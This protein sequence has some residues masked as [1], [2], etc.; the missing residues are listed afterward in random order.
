MTVFWI[1]AALML[2]AALGF[3]LLPLARV[4]K[5]PDNDSRDVNVAVYRGQLQELRTD[6][7]TGAI[8]DDQY[9]EA[10][11]DLER[12]LVQDTALPA[13]TPPAPKRN[14]A[15]TTSLAAGVAAFAIALYFVVGN[16]RALSPASFT[17]QD[18][19]A[20]IEQLAQHLEQDP[21]NAEGW[22]LL[23]RSYHGL[24]QYKE[25]A[26][27]FEKASLLTPDDAQ[28]LADYA[29]A[30]ARA[31]EG[32][33]EGKPMLLLA[34][35]LQADPENVKALA[36]SGAGAY[37][38][39]DYKLAA[40]H[41]QRLLARIPAE[42]EEAKLVQERIAEARTLAAAGSPGTVNIRGT[43]K[44]S[45]RLQSRVGGEDTL[46]VYAQ[47]DNSRMPLAIVRA[48][49]KELPYSFILDDS[50]SMAGGAKLSSADEVRVV[51]RVSKSGVARNSP[52][53]LQGVAASVKP[54]ASEVEVVIDQVVGAEAN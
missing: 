14:Y 49:A 20:L 50:K 24:G 47:A 26:V 45:P 5:A 52:G 17:S 18:P 23:A 25:A 28:L 39:G 34:R 6:L 9:R 40:E 43:V 30:V 21:D 51:A 31:S 41:W 29:D 33:L 36:L 37:G 53:D 7:A 4:R 1:L 13:A 32:R 8:S 38:A 15:L 12:N 48:Q 42:S 2:L 35:S 54:G 22:A 44:L 11:S 46:F 19:G 16:P 27:A 10:V 3:L